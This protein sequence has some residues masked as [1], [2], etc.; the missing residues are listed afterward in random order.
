MRGRRGA[1]GTCGAGARA[2][3]G[4]EPPRSLRTRER[5]R[6]SGAPSRARKPAADLRGNPHSEMSLVAARSDRSEASLLPHGGTAV[7]PCVEA[8]VRRSRASPVAQSEP[9]EERA[10]RG[11]CGGRGA[12][13]RDRLGGGPG[14][15]EGRGGEPRGSGLQCRETPSGVGVSEDEPSAFLEARGSESE[16][17]G[18]HPVLLPPPRH[19]C[20]RVALSDGAECAAPGRPEPALPEPTEE[21]RKVLPSVESAAADLQVTLGLPAARAGQVAELSRRR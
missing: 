17:S 13:V 20:P 8:S 12:P 4:D 2:E 15:A 9:A 11:S 16:P 3:D 1:L 14:A 7:R 19:A 18:L 10:A 21:C 5:P 6:P